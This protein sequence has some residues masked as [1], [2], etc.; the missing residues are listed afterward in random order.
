M[1]GLA[2]AIEPGSIVA[3]DTAAFIYQIEA[4]PAYAVVVGPFFVAL[5][6]GRFRATTSVLSLMEM[7]VRPL[8]LGR[9]EV[10]DDYELLLLSYP[11]LRVIDVDRHVA[12]R[13][14]EL[15]ANYRLRPADALQ[16]ATGLEA[17][18]SALLTND[19]ALARV[20]ELRVL[21]IDSFLPTP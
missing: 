7:A 5:A 21:L 6:Q 1:D 8:Q 15:R 11:N 3:I 17:G 2:A 20:R 16:L 19:R 10:A 9:P 4:S 12:R 14:A 18:A 13:A